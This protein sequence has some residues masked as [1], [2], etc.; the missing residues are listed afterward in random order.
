[1]GWSEGFVVMWQ[2]LLNE[3]KKKIS[4]RECFSNCYINSMLYKTHYEK[5]H[6]RM[7]YL[8]TPRDLLLITSAVS[9]LA[10]STSRP[11]VLRV[12][13][14]WF[15]QHLFLIFLNSPQNPETAVIKK[16]KLTKLRDAIQDIVAAVTCY[17]FCETRSQ[18]K[19]TTK[20]AGWIFFLK[21]HE[22]TA[23][24]P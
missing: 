20:N 12:D 2:L 19:T 21:R 22:M 15:E 11:P 9:C 16:K 13:R 17:C 4:P 6:A 23:S 24:N 10:Y 3:R 7:P 1:M 18:K 14:L 8:S 5:S